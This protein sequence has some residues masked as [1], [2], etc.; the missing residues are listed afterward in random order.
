[1]ISKVIVGGCSG[2]AL[3]FHAAHVEDAHRTASHDV[4]GTPA[5]EHA[6]SVIG[7]SRQ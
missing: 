3:D 7:P 5:L 6:L 2:G 1:M 4:V